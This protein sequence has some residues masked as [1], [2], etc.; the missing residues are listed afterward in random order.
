MPAR[1]KQSKLFKACIKCKYL[2][3]LDTPKCPVCGSEN[4]TENWSGMVV[5]V[6]IEKSDIAK[7]LNIKVP[8]R[9]AI[10][11]GT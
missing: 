11:L 8:G 1:R 3:P 9:Y 10:R 7:M 4:F 6:D 5:I 2:V